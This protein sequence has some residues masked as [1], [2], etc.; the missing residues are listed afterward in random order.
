MKPAN[1][2]AISSVLLSAAFFI[3]LSPFVYSQD[4]DSCREFSQRIRTTYNFRPALLKNQAESEM[5]SAA[6]DKIWES[7]KA[8]PRE[9]VPC[10][11]Q[12]LEDPS[13]DAWFRFDGS[14]LLVSLDPSDAS[15]KLQIKSFAANNLDDVDLRVWVRTLTRLGLEGF[16]VSEPG[17]RWLA[18]PK[19]RYFL[20]EHGAYEV[21]MLQGALFIFGSMDEAVAVPAL[22]RIVNQSNHPGR[23][24]ALAVLLNANTPESRRSLKQLD[25]SSFS[26]TA[27]KIIRAELDHPDLFEPRSKPKTN[28]REFLE[29]FEALL[30]NDS[31]AFFELVDRV[32]DGEKDVVATMT[33]EDLPLLRKVRRRMI[34][35]GNQHSIDYYASFTKIIRTIL[36]LNANV[37]STA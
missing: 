1:I 17:E 2:P 15:K 3:V 8:N 10:L 12:A 28:R 36:L 19:A 16:D 24:A 6:M 35:G 21:K 26:S 14:N 22:L 31:R 27:G 5:K 25:V 37:K 34:A 32:P 9:L 29:A 11:R 23:E 13:A 7:T 33:E 4:N 30:N 18:Y 20:P